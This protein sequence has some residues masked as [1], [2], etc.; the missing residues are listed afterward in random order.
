MAVKLLKWGNSVGIRLSQPVLKSAGLAVGD[1]CEVRLLDSG[2]IRL[3]PS[4]GARP[5]DNLPE[6]PRINRPETKW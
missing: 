1:Y 4:K 5:A 6:L 2:E 3:C